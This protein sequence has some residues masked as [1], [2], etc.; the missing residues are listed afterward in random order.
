MRSDD[1]VRELVRRIRAH[2]ADIDAVCDELLA[3]LKPQPRI[4]QRAALRELR[5][6]MKERGRLECKLS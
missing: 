6:R 3:R 5:R 4:D 2:S 1:E